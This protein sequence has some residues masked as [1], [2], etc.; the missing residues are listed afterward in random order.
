MGSS[1][2]YFMQIKVLIMA[3]ISRTINFIKQTQRFEPALY[4]TN[5]IYNCDPCCDL[6]L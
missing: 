5:E 4:S 6:I 2:P 1:E 3:P